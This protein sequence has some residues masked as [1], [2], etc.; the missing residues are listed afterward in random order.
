MGNAFTNLI[1]GFLEA[2][3]NEAASYV[4]KMLTAVLAMT[5]HIEHCFGSVNMDKLSSVIYM[6]ASSVIILKFLKKGFMIYILWRDGDSDVSPRSMLTGLGTAVFIT[7]AFPKLY[8]IA[9]E[10]TVWFAEEIIKSFGV[11]HIFNGDVMLITLSG[12]GI[13][14]I[15]IIIVYVVIS[16]ILIIQL[17]RR[18]VDLFVLRMGIPIAC[19]GLIDSD[20][21]VFRPYITQFFR[22]LFTSVVQISLFSLSLSCIL[23]DIGNNALIAIAIMSAA[24]STPTLMQNVILPTSGGAVANKVAKTAQIANVVRKIIIKR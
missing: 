14:Q 6:F 11:G 16:L 22:A 20:G 19:V 5:L 7:V 24:L 9:A 4:G 18:G 23:S 3:I 21:G 13:V 1:S 2:I 10:V 17:L 12:F 8:D 15:I